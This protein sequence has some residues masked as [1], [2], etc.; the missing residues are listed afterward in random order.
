MACMRRKAADQKGKRD[1]GMV[2]RVALGVDAPSA[3]C[4]REQDEDLRDGLLCLLNG[5]QMLHRSDK[6]L[7]NGHDGRSDLL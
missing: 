7:I 2:L 6:D 1:F 5:D 4:T 3:P